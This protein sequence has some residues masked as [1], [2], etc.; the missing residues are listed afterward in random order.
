MRRM[1]SLGGVVC[2]GLA[3]GGPAAGTARADP[4]LCAEH[5]EGGRYAA[6][7]ERDSGFR[8]PHLDAAQHPGDRELV[9]IAKVS[10]A[11][12]ASL[13]PPQAGAERHVVALEDD[14]ADAVGVV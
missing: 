5:V 2:V 9:D 7:G 12:R 11:E 10:E 3:D 4:G 13:E 8:E 6:A 14:L 1:R